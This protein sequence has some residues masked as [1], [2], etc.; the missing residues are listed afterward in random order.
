ME[1]HPGY[2]YAERPPS[3]RIQ[4][5]A[6]YGWATLDFVS[7]I[8]SLRNLV[9]VSGGG[10]APVESI[11]TSVVKPSRGSAITSVE[12]VGGAG[13]TPFISPNDWIQITGINLVPADTPASGVSWSNAPEFTSG[14]MPTQLNGVS[15][16]VNGKPAYVEFYCSAA[17]SPVCSTDQINVLSPPDPSLSGYAQLVVT[18]SVGT[19]SDSAVN[20]N[21]ISPSFLRFGASRY[22]AATHSDYSILGP[23]SLNPGLSTPAKRGEV[24]VLWAVGFGLPVQPLNAGVSTQ[25]GSMPETPVCTVGGN[26]A[27]ISIALVSPGL[28]QLNLTIPGKAQIGD[29][30]ITCIYRGA[31]T[32]DGALLAIE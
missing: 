25:S 14:K 21:A 22:V 31:A 19:A 13:G 8:P 6:N 27:N 11:D 2:L 26:A 28:Y 17:T 16:T 3:S 1:L 7:G 4:L 12:T 29:N 24:A 10:S 23:P 18:S 30:P 32:P 20:T 9:V 5:S 15:V